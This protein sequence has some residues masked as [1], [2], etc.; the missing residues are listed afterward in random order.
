M[1]PRPLSATILGILNLGYGLFSLAG[2]LFISPMAKSFA[3]D[4]GM[5]PWVWVSG[6]VQ[7]GAGLILVVAAI[8]LFSCKNWARLLSIAWAIF[9]IVVTLA[10]IPVIA[11]YTHLIPGTDRIPPSVKAVFV[12][13]VTA[14]STLFSMAYPAALL[15]FM[16]RPKFA[17]ACRAGYRSSEPA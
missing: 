9:A 16:T 7:A 6:L 5:V 12:N 1:Q 13:L 15:F 11:K 4:P 2:L 14:L 3:N 17:A 8:G 10:T